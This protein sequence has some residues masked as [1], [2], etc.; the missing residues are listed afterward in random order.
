M[1]RLSA[2][3]LVFAQLGLSG[4]AS[5]DMDVDL[6]QYNLQWSQTNPIRGALR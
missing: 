3:R 4:L 6:P 1:R 2:W 5:A